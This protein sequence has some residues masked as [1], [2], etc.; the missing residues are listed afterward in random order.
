MTV[1]RVLRPISMFNVW[2]LVA[3]GLTTSFVSVA[4][5]V[6]DDPSEV[7]IGT[8]GKLSND[9]KRALLQ[10]EGNLFRMRRAFFYSPTATPVLL[11]VVYNI[12][13]TTN[14]IKKAAAREIPY[15][16]VSNTN[17]TLQFKQK[18]ITYGWTSSGVYTVFHP[19]V[20]SMMQIQLVY[21]MLRAVHKM[22]HQNSPE[23]DAF[24]WDGSQSLPT[25]HL[26]IQFNFL[27]CIPSEDLFESVLMDFNAMASIYYL[28]LHKMIILFGLLQQH[29]TSSM[30]CNYRVYNYLHDIIIVQYDQGPSPH[31]H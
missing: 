15:C 26:N 6:C 28:L 14:I 19:A 2:H 13:Y 23:V 12:T 22:L 21:V 20:L 11:K 29:S 9:L 3:I 17:S 16:F 1:A 8:C 31:T 27:S 25:L 10:D 24:L 5:L 4:C 18:N 7:S 30:T